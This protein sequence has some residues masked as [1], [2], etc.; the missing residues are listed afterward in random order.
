V[1]R[2]FLLGF[3]LCL[4]CRSAATAPAARA[5]LPCPYEENC[6]CPVPGISERWRAAYCMVATE[7]DDF[8]NEGVQACF[9]KTAGQ[10]VG[11]HSDCE[12]NAHWKAAICELLDAQSDRAAPC[13]RADFVPRAVREGVQ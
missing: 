4:A 11:V 5:N 9:Q 13:A 8:L 1:K 7:T 12:R 10:P 2:S 6:A 3:I